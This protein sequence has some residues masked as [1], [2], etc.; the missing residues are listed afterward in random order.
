MENN[1]L[2]KRIQYLMD[3]FRMIRLTKTI[4]FKIFMRQFDVNEKFNTSIFNARCQQFDGFIRDE[5]LSVYNEYK[6]LR[7][8]SVK[9]IDKKDKI[10]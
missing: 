9:K 4:K 8:I 2:N 7:K 5:L 6:L 10:V 3:R 1:N